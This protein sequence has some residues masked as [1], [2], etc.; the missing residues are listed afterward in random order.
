MVVPIGSA[1]IAVATMLVVT[2]VFTARGFAR[3]KANKA[4]AAGTDKEVSQIKELGD[5]ATALVPLLGAIGTL[6]TTFVNPKVADLTKSRDAAVAS[7]DTARREVM[8]VRDTVAGL[9]RFELRTWSRL[10][11]VTV[12]KSAEVRF[13]DRAVKTVSGR[14]TDASPATFAATG[15]ATFQCDSGAFTLLV[16][17]PTRIFL[18]PSSP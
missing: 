15:P 8:A 9:L 10:P 14:C 2:G 12:A 6:Y 13:D 11:A 7:A 16:T 4:A 5:F 1:I 17:R 18:V 3:H